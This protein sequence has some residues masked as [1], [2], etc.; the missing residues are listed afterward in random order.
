M[1]LL[2][3]NERPEEPKLLTM[4][5]DNSNTEKTW[6]VEKLRVELEKSLPN[7]LGVSPDLSLTSAVLFKQIPTDLLPLLPNLDGVTFCHLDKVT[8][9]QI[10]AVRKAD[11]WGITPPR[12][13]HVRLDGASLEGEY[14]VVEGGLVKATTRSLHQALYLLTL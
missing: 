12:D 9:E 10:I 3:P 2:T 1:A 8:T 11:G 6:T 5:K 13:L 7:A 14:D 4:A